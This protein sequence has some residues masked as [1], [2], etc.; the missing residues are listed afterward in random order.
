MEVFG[1]FLECKL[2]D[3]LCKGMEQYL[4]VLVGREYEYTE[5]AGAVNGVTSS[6]PPPSFS[7]TPPFLGKKR[8]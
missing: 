2:G 3:Q 6:Y 7:S 4:K 5:I 8:S 1:G